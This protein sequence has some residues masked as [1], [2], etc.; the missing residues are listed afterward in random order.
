MHAANQELEPGFVLCAVISDITWSREP[1]FMR[2]DN[3]SLQS[4]E[5]WIRI[6]RNFANTVHKSWVSSVPTLF[7]G[8]PAC[9][10]EMRGL[11]SVSMLGSLSRLCAL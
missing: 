11:H 5:S 1:D 7:T 4:V 9:E 8:D 3:R 6:Q 10:C 2:E